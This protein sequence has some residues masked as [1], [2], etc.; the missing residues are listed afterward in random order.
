[1]EAKGVL[2]EANIFNRMPKGMFRFQLK[3]E[4]DARMA[5][6]PSRLSVQENE[7]VITDRM[8]KQ[9]KFKVEDIEKVWNLES[10]F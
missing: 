10:R 9:S 7:L 5:S 2:L 8:G 4:K 1:M 6:K 3:N